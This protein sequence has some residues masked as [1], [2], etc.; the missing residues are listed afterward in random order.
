MSL[1]DLP[2]ALNEDSKATNA[3]SNIYSAYGEGAIAQRADCDWYTEC[4]NGNFVLKG[5]PHS[6]CPRSKFDEERLKGASSL[7]GKV[8]E[9]SSMGSAGFK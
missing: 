2:F 7:H 3:V 4:K 1:F 9:I 8:A 6:S 5:A